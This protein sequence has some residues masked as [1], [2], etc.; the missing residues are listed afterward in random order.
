MNCT[1]T[2][3]NQTYTEEDF[4]EYLKTQIPTSINNLSPIASIPQNLISGQ[5]AFGTLQYATPEVKAIL[6]ENPTSIDMIEA[7][8]RT[9][10][11]RSVG[12]MEKYSIK[13]GDIIKHFG[14][15]AD[16]KIK[17][18]KAR[19]T[20]IH[21]KGTPE[22]ESTWY[23]EG[24]TQEGIKAIQRYKDGAAAI[25]FEI[26]KD[27]VQPQQQS[28]DNQE[29]NTPVAAYNSNKVVLEKGNLDTKTKNETNTEKKIEPIKPQS[30]DFITNKVN[31]SFDK[32]G[33]V[34]VLTSGKNNFDFKSAVIKYIL[35][36]LG[37][38][39]NSDK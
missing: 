23:K 16:G 11:T 31:S 14:K 35:K 33:Y 17:N 28:S 21:Y 25:E 13:V 20:A 4:L 22:F 12:E 7:G 19:V 10:T 9:R 1:I 18:I 3:N 15:S 26:I 8:L 32:Y 2:Y 39:F 5:E 38:E 30:K 37:L 24:W 29:N 27:E 34:D 36:D 6:G